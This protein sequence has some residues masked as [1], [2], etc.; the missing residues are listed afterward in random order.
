ML[1]IGAPADQDRSP[2]GLSPRER[3][4][5]D[6]ERT[7]WR[8]PGSKEAAIRERLGLSSTRYYQLLNAVLDDPAA[9]EYDP[10]TV[11][12]ARRVRDYRRRARIDGR[13]AR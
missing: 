9:F 3:A 10:L 8:Y 1:A 7:W 6:F 13:S 11:K 2:M 4:I 12:R 5:I